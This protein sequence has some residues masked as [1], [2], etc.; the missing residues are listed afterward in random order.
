MTM[1]VQTRAGHKLMWN[2]TF[3]S[4]SEVANERLNTSESHAAI[5]H[6]KFRNVLRPAFKTCCSG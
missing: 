2:S 5:V 1:Y 3:E 6:D 4:V